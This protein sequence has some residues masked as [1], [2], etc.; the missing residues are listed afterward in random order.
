MNQSERSQDFFF[1]FSPNWRKNKKQRFCFRSSLFCLMVNYLARTACVVR[2]RHHTL[3]NARALFASRR[4]RKNTG[5]KRRRS[6]TYKKSITRYI[7]IILVRYVCVFSPVNRCFCPSTSSIQ[8]IQCPCQF[9]V[10][11]RYKI[12]GKKLRDILQTYLFQVQIKYL[13]NG[14]HIYSHS[15]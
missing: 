7:R 13:S 14:G 12:S 8:L 3:L 11:K 5:R 9:F 2:T 6:M 4:T 1:C 15:I 10:L